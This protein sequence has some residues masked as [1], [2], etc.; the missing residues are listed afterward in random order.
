[1]ASAETLVERRTGAIG[2]PQASA[3][4]FGQLL[5]LTA[6]IPA[7]GGL[8]PHPA[9][10]AWA[11]TERGT[12]PQ[13]DDR[14]VD[15]NSV[16]VLWIDDLGAATRGI[17]AQATG[18]APV[19]GHVDWIPQNVWWRSETE[20]EGVLDWDSLARL[21]EPALAGMAAAGYRGGVTSVEE[22]AAFA[23][24]YRS[25]ATGWSTDHE[26]LFW[27]AGLWVALF[28]AK[29]DL[30]AGRMTSLAEGEARERFNLAARG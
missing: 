19:V 15:L 9:W 5:R 14:E 26:A 7:I 28:D 23:D 27:A 21:P 20:I 13:P 6:Q 8:D 1:M 3:Q 24:E 16:N 22:S 10:T 29:K 4:L 12:W 25:H 17:L 30:I 18:F 11:H 2:T